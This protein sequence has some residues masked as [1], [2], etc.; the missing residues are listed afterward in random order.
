MFTRT[1]N[2]PSPTTNTHMHSHIHIALVQWAKL[3]KGE[4]GGIEGGGGAGLN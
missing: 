2:Y 1:P 3:E 4:W